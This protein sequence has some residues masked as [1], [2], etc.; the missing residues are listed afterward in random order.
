MK[1]RANLEELKPI[2]RLVAATIVVALTASMTVVLASAES[3]AAQESESV[4]EPSADQPDPVSPEP[5]TGAEPQGPDDPLADE[6]APESVPG[7]EVVVPRSGR[8]ASQPDFV[9][10]RVLWSNVRE[11]S[12]RLEE[13]TESHLGSVDQVRSLR[14]SEKALRLQLKALDIDSQKTIAELEVAER[15]LR[16]RA[17]NAFTAPDAGTGVVS[18]LDH[19]DLLQAQAQQFL[20]ESVFK[21]DD[22]AIDRIIQLKAEL[23]GH[24][25]AAFD[26]LSR[27]VET[28]DRMDIVVKDLKRE[29]ESAELELDVFK[30]GSEFFIDDLVFPISGPYDIPLV[31]SWGFPRAPGTPDEHWHEGMDIL[32]P[33][34][35]PI[36]ASERGV[37]TKVGEASA[38]GGL[39]VWIQGESGTKWYYAHMSAIRDGLKV[40]DS[41]EVGEVIG[42][43][44][45]SGNAV[46]TPDHLH[47]QVHPNGGRPVNPYPILKVISDRDFV[48][49][50]RLAE[51]A[52][53]DSNR[54]YPG[55]LTAGGPSGLGGFLR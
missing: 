52:L 2:A 3:A 19:D 4:Q 5:G 9:E 47:L 51:E 45:Q 28:I 17:L 7:G 31:D 1:M 34:G 13:A 26:R 24:S 42:F 41:V 23:D 25:Q 35:T 22:A 49:A 55:P 15:R 21:V 12:D 16:D 11:A 33:G 36:V 37:A 54:E 30:A 44:G 32:S 14:I 18:A 50:A 43:V 10:A 53:R 48:Q 39:R 29:V 6:S 27:V 46:G 20:V 40:G 8:Y 38:L